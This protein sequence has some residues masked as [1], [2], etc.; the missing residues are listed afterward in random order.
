MCCSQALERGFGG[1]VL[2]SEDVDEVLKL[3]VFNTYIFVYMEVVDF[4]RIIYFLLSLHKHLC[5]DFYCLFSPD[6]LFS[7]VFNIS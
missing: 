3:K 6:L 4:S 5:L 7:Y 1:V 2:K